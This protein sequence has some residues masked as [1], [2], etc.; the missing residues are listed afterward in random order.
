MKS[1]LYATLKQQEGIK[2]PSISKMNVLTIALNQFLAIHELPFKMLFKYRAMKICIPGH[3]IVR[4]ASKAKMSVIKG[5]SC[6][7]FFGVSVFLWC[8]DPIA[9]RISEPLQSY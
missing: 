2:V 9:C 6:S 8:L 5:A 1:A 7:L 4:E 3:T